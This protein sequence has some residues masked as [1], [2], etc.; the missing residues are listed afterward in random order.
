M[1]VE[2]LPGSKRRDIHVWEENSFLIFVSAIS[3]SREKLLF[4]KMYTDDKLR[5][6]V[7]SSNR[8]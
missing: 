5:L 7:P 1:T 8:C 4:K 3:F 6:H 2:M